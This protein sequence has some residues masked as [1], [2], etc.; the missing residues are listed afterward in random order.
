MLR[1]LSFSL[2][3]LC[4]TSV[5][6]N[7]LKDDRLVVLGK[8]HFQEERI[9][10][11]IEQRFIVKVIEQYLGNE[12]ILPLVDMRLFRDINHQLAIFNPEDKALFLTTKLSDNTYKIDE[13]IKYPV[14]YQ[15]PVAL[16]NSYKFIFT[17]KLQK[18]IQLQL[19]KHKSFNDG[20]FEFMHY[21]TTSG[22]QLT[23][24]NIA[25]P[26]YHFSAIR[27]YLLKEL[28]G[29]SDY[30][31]FER[32]QQYKVKIKNGKV[33]VDVQKFRSRIQQNPAL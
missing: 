10:T 19:D 21:E 18:T 24:Y 23:F 14:N 12:Y 2:Y 25:L 33:V 4:T 29:F 11:E 9:G 17:E 16:D 27:S 32:K 8:V 22:H 1:I 28:E 7:I 26:V 6:S 5:A 30:F 13:Y 31:K 20:A 15:F 3:V